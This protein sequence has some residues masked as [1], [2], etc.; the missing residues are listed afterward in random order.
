MRLD[1]GKISEGDFLGFF[2]G[3][4]RRNNKGENFLSGFFLSHRFENLLRE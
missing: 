4:V 2:E 3:G 1:V